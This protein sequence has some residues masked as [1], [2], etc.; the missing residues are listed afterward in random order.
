MLE[1]VRT[2]T[3]YELVTALPCRIVHV[4]SSSKRIHDVTVVQQQVL[5]GTG[6]SD[7]A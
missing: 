4:R 6:V 5:E 7:T 1:T 2:L 3:G